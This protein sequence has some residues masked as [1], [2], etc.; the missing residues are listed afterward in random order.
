MSSSPLSRPLSIIILACVGLSFALGHIAA[1]L[2]FDQGTSVVTAVFF[3]SGFVVLVLAVYLAIRR[4]P[5]AVP[6]RLYGWQLALG[7]LLTVQ[8]V[9]LYTAVASIPVGI[10][11]LFMHTFAILLALIT[12]VFGGPA[13]TRKSILLML[14]C[15]FGLFLSMDVP[16]LIAADAAG[17]STWF[18]GIG[19]AVTAALAFALGLWITDNKLPSLV[20]AVRSFYST[21]VILACAWGIARA[22][23]LGTYFV[24]PTELSVWVYVFLLSAF[25]GIAFIA[26]F[27]LAPRMNMAQNAPALHIEPVASLVLGWIILGQSLTPIQIIGGACVVVG[28]MLIAMQRSALPPSSGK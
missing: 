12:W 25:Y 5:P 16:A 4:I 17:R 20:G 27:V 23:A 3:R 18:T 15:L 21:L 26:L 28:I 9:G 7:L 10:A 19:A 6:P 1:R 14:L 13:P 11:L 24:W 8:S 22:E 2:A